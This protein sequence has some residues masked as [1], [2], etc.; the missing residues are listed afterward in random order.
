MRY[1][2]EDFNKLLALATPANAAKLRRT[3]VPLPYSADAIRHYLDI[4]SASQVQATPCILD[5][6]Q[7]REL[8]IMG[9][10]LVCSRVVQLVLPC[11]IE[12]ERPGLLFELACQHN[13]D[14]TLLEAGLDKLAQIMGTYGYGSGSTGSSLQT[15]KV[16]VCKLPERYSTQ[17]AH[18]M[19]H[20]IDETGYHGS[21]YQQC[22]RWSWV[23]KPDRVQAYIQGVQAGAEE[24]AKGS[25]VRLASHPLRQQ[26][27]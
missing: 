13:D 25:L 11:L 10:A 4:V 22:P 8:Y 23:R 19:F 12:L 3:I 17:L 27:T 1:F 2:S 20:A 18:Q 7:S 6:A 14:I 26:L 9:R 15:F 24:R 5:L 16:D 21:H